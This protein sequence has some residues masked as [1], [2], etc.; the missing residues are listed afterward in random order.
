M[1]QNRSDEA[2]PYTLH[3]FVEVGAAAT[4]ERPAAAVAEREAGEEGSG[5]GVGFPPSR[6]LRGDV[7]DG[8][9]SA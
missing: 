3:T 6:P 7:R 8:V 5:G 9:L 2:T 4:A 1:T